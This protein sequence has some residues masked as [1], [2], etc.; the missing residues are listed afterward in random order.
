MTA[1]QVHALAVFALVL[2][3]Q[4]GAIA[5]ERILSFH[6]DIEVHR[7]GELTVLETIRVRSERKQIKRGIYRDFP[8]R[9]K[10]RLGNHVVV[11]F[12]VLEVLR[13]GQAERYHTQSQ[14]N[15]VR[16]YVGD[17]SIV[18]QPGVYTY[19]FKYRTDRQVGF[20]AD[21]DELYFN[22]TG[23]GWAFPIDHAKAVLDLPSSVPRAEV[24]ME[25]YT[26]TT[27]SK[28]A[29]YQAKLDGQRVTFETTRPLGRYE[30]LTVVAMWPKGHVEPPTREEKL[31]FFVRDNRLA[32]FASLGLL[33][34]LLYYVF[35]WLL[36]GRDPEKGTIIARFY[37]PRDIS[38]AAARF[39]SR[40]GYDSKC[41]AAAL[42]D[43]AVKGRLKLNE[44][45]GLYTVTREDLSED[46]LPKEERIVLKTLLGSRRSLKLETD[47]HS[48][49]GEAVR[50]LSESLR[51]QYEVTYFLNN[52][53]YLFPGLAIL[54]GTV[55]VVIASADTSGPLGFLAFFVAMWTLGVVALLY[56]AA[57]SWRSVVSSGAVQLPNAVL[58]TLFA[59]PFI[60]GEVFVLAMFA[61]DTSPLATVILVAM[62][63]LTVLFYQLLKAPTH[64][65]RLVMD[66]I[67]GF[68]MYLS[69]AE[70]DRLALLE[71]PEK[72]PELFEAYLPYA[73][74]L[75]VEQAWAE[76]FADVLEGPAREQATSTYRPTWYTGHAL[77]ASALAGAV[78]GA[79]ASTIASSATAP[80]SSSGGGG[81][82]F[83]GG[84]GGGGGGG[85]W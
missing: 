23:H 18:L 17:R 56:A 12:E 36:V 46:S 15:G 34:M 40:M 64:V 63:P 20:F 10:D 2:G 51:K 80:G 3:A 26:G 13:D 66:E 44:D 21:H 32:V 7:S 11:G 5:D 67:D 9:Y 71:S 57:R 85:G 58:L 84:G 33:A 74:A 70:R 8:T 19:R 35:A 59:V 50:K 49:I 37:P 54:V 72:T 60:G 48:T 73:L 82:G 43:L 42:I 4:S 24:R 53:K 55:A 78:G 31:R 27:G 68:K 75:D 76:Q 41:F 65:G 81:G 77:S 30:G 29:D 25:A 45:N 69:V 1:R 52:T 61:Q 22:V 62:V 28:G 47:N 14:R 6:S 79:L 38:P 83:S 16:T 39:I